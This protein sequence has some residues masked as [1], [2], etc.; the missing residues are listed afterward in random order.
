MT[1][2]LSSPEKRSNISRMFIFLFWVSVIL[3]FVRNGLALTT[4]TGGKL[5]QSIPTPALATRTTRSGLVVYTPL[6]VGYC[7]Y[8]KLPCTPFFRPQLKL[9]LDLLV[10]KF[11]DRAAAKPMYVFGGCGIFSL[12]ISLFT[13]LWMLG[14]KINRGTPFIETPLPLIV[15]VTFMIAMMCILL[16]LL[17]EMITRTF[18]ESQGKAIY[19][20]RSTRKM[21]QTMARGD[22]R[23]EIFKDDRENTYGGQVR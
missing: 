15:V 14:L 3:A 11:L 6:P 8:G 5:A 19:N 17:A 2:N 7:W 13:F 1:L 22:Q 23:E 9:L 18:Y 21:R 16:G 4:S 10:V 20:I 12:V